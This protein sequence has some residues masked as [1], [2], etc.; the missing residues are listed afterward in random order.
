MLHAGVPSQARK[1]PEAV[2]DGSHLVHRES[3]RVWLVHR[4]RDVQYA[5]DAS[6]KVFE[7][8]IPEWLKRVINAG[9]K[10]EPLEDV[11]LKRHRRE[12]EKL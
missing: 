5:I 11:T 4:L 10:R 9:R 6:D 7:P 2:L 1:E 8:A 12:L 3:E